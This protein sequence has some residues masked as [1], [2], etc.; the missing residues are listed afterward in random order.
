MKCYHLVLKADVCSLRCRINRGHFC[1]CRD[2]GGAL[3]HVTISTWEILNVH[4]KKVH[5]GEYTAVILSI[6]I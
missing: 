3:L 4:F 1:L 2:D 5:R 6:Y